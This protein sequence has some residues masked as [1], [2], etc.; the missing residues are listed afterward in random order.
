MFSIHA[1]ISAT[2]VLPLEIL[3]QNLAGLFQDPHSA[4]PEISSNPLPFGGEPRLIFL[5]PTWNFSVSCESGE[6]VENDA[7]FC[8]RESGVVFLS[9][10]P[11]HRLRFVF[12]DDVE[13]DFTNHIL[14]IVDWLKEIP[15]A[16]VFDEA[17]KPW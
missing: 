1:Y 5:W 3:K 17:G 13:R 12:A 2:D 11:V 14:W 7:A 10:L 9:D 4:P 6:A 15:S 8:S 16:V